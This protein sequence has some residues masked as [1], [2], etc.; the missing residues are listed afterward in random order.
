ML[1]HNFKIRIQSQ[2]LPSAPGTRRVGTLPRCCHSLVDRCRIA[3]PIHGRAGGRGERQ[4]KGSGTMSQPD[5]RIKSAYVTAS[6]PF[7]CCVSCPRKLEQAQYKCVRHG[8]HVMPFNFRSSRHPRCLSTLSSQLHCVP[9][10]PDPGSEPDL[11]P[12]LKVF[13]AAVRSQIR[14]ISTLTSYLHL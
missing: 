2:S 10:S 7:S 8:R 6:P 11:R 1:G 5:Q 9:A 13:V 14:G 12:F 4:N 3:E